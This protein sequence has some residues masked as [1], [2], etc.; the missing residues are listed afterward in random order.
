LKNFWLPKI[1]LPRFLGRRRLQQPRRTW[2][3]R[4]ERLEDRWVPTIT[5]TNQAITATEGVSG[6]FTVATFTDSDPSPVA[7]YSATI[8]WGDGTTTPGT[9][10]QNGS[11][12][13][14]IGTHTYADETDPASLPVTVQ[15]QENNGADQDAGTANSTANVAESD[16]L[17][18]GIVDILATETQFFSGAVA[19]FADT[20]ASATA[21]DFTATIDWGDGTT[22][23][24]TVIGGTGTFTVSGTHT[25]PDE[26][27]FTVGVTFSDDAPGTASAAASSTATVAEADVLTGTGVTVTA[28]EG[29]SFSG[30]VATFTN[31][32]TTAPASNFSASIVWGDGTTTA[33]TVGGS[34]GNFTVT[35]THTFAEDGS[36]TVR[37]TLTDSP[38]GTAT[39]TATSTANIAERDLTATSTTISAREGTSLSRAVASF[40]DA[41]SPDAASAFTA[42]INWGDGTTSTGT[43]TG[44]AGSFTVNGTH[45]YADEGSFTVAVQTTE[46]GVPNGTAS[47]S[48]T[49]QV[50]EADE[51]SATGTAVSAMQ[52]QT[53]NGQV[54]ALTTTY[55]SNTA[56]DLNATIDWGDGTIT[57]GTVNGSN[58]SF[59]VLGAHAYANL[60]SFPVTVTI[61]DDGSG[62]AS[63]T[64]TTTATVAASVFPPSTATSWLDRVYRDLLHRALDPFGQAAWTV[65]LNQGVSRQLVVGM[66]EQSVE[67]RTD[68][69]QTLYQ[70]LLH[71]SADPVGLNGWVNALGSG[72][73]IL[74]VEAGILGSPEFFQDSGSTK[75][76]F[77]NALYEDLLGREPDPGGLA[78]AL[79]ALANNVSRQAVAAAVL[80]RDEFHADLIT[81][82]YEQFLQ[83]APDPVGFNLSMQ[84]L[85]GGFSEEGLIAVLLGSD[86][87][88]LSATD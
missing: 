29:Q 84:A 64:A 55:T 71:R 18:P 69:V 85:R 53:F 52:G 31:T 34:A 44:S 7:D 16:S 10:S 74:E 67:Y 65:L 27:S 57:T 1:R 23:A 35:G 48:S 49:A 43:V 6:S 41:G 11:T 36:L 80:A 2:T 88:F 79:T 81:A 25:Y 30:T 47:A 50:A 39:A 61:A 58:G 13:S 60:G 82:L 87:Y 5:V 45:T 12:F 86:E 42:F 78:V 19:T 75:Q 22:T 20:N 56:N 21:G 33:G 66:I 14:V 70:Q 40:T 73:T 28:T 4:L 8:N 76:G 62:T 83:R 72:M 32:N 24:G 77:V 59:T 38:P 46:T 51:L 9:V 17:T 26:G 54:A 68:E 3:P 15:I 63:V 37:V